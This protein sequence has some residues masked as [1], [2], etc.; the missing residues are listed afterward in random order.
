MAWE[1]SHS[2]EVYS[3]ADYNLRELPRETLEI[4]F[5]EWR[6]AQGKGG[7]IDSFNPGFSEK[8]YKRALVHAKTLPCDVLANFIWE[9]ASEFATCDNGGFNAWLCP[10]GCGCHTVPFELAEG[11]DGSDWGQYGQ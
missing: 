1:W 10:H 5:A 7:V 4:I 8:K 11:D 2:P 6:A 9:R 3:A